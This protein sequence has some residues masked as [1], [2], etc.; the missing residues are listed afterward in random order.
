MK[1]NYCLAFAAI[2][3]FAAVALGAFGAHGLKDFLSE[4]GRANNFETAVRYQ[5][6]HALALALVGLAVDRCHNGW[7]RVAGIAFFS[8]T[9]LFSGMLYAYVFTDIKTF[10]MFIVP[11]GGVTLLVG[12]L[13]LAIAACK[14]TRAS[15]GNAGVPARN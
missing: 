2:L 12:W 10:V 15:P 7:L 1:Q 9:L 5:M 3:G 8:G 13:A 14:G 6:Y 11:I 4:R